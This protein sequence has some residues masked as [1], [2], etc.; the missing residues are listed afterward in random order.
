MR[1]RLTPS[2]AGSPPSRSRA[3]TTSRSRA[4]GLRHR[5]QN[6]RHRL[7][8]GAL[9]G[10]SYRD[11]IVWQRAIEMTLAIYKLTDNFPPRELYGLSSQLR[12]AA[13]SVSSNIAEG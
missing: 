4:Q 10:D 13:V 3:R 9:M 2:S 12:R 7:K 11:L 6:L 8:G 1:S 5:A